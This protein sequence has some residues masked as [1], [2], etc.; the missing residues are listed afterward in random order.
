M[1]NP[2]M[3]GKLLVVTDPALCDTTHQ[4]P[5]S[6]GRW[7]SWEAELMESAA[8]EVFGASLMPQAVLAALRAKD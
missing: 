2:Q 7:F 5:D 4:Q 6:V 1:A 8:L 3:M